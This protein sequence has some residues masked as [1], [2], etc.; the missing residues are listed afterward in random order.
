LRLVG[1][2]W[3]LQEAVSKPSGAN[4][5]ALMS[6]G[7]DMDGTRFHYAD[8][9]AQQEMVV[10]GVDHGVAVGPMTRGSSTRRR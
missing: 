7:V 1:E 8:A 5:N 10:A 6:A 4:A 3:A 2:Y 9:A